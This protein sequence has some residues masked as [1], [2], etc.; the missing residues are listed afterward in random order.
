MAKKHKEA[1]ENDDK[2]DACD[3]KEER[4]SD[5]TDDGSDLKGFVVDEDNESDGVSEEE[6]ANEIAKA[7]FQSVEEYR[8]EMDEIR[9][10]LGSK[11]RRDEYMQRKAAA[12]SHK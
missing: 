5:G 7:S 10:M 4:S 8:R 1:D 6:E 12:S 3:S 2:G 11:R 9:A